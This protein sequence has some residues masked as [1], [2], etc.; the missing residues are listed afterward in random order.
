[1]NAIRNTQYA[2]RKHG[3]LK[4]RT[5]VVILIF[6]FCVLNFLGCTMVSRKG[7]AGAPGMLEPQAVFRFADIPVPVGFKL[8]SKDTY[9]FEGAGVRVGLLQYKGKADPGRAINFYKEQMPMYNWRLLNVIEYGERLMNF[10]REDEICNI[11]LIP[12]GRTL[13]ITVSVGP[14]T[15]APKK[16]IRRVK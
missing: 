9:A 14:K 5:Y 2:I 13:Y 10:D 7:K 12:R 11:K 1:M 8:L 4:S 6:A 15:Q 16:S 3:I